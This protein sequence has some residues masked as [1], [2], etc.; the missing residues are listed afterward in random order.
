MT[1]ETGRSVEQ[2]LS[3]TLRRHAYSVF[4]TGAARV[5]YPSVRQEGAKTFDYDIVGP[6]ILIGEPSAET[7]EKD[8]G[9]NCVFGF[10]KLRS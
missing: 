7:R 1:F 9:V 8:G 2:L 6:K 5:L 10:C 3:R 4:H